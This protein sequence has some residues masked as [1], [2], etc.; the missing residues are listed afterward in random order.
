[1]HNFNIF[2]NI[3]PKENVTENIY[4]KIFGFISNQ[5]SEK[6]IIEDIKEEA[7]NNEENLEKMQEVFVI[8]NS[9]E[10]KNKEDNNISNNFNKKN[11]IIISDDDSRYFFTKRIAK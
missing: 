11:S 4:T 5:A 1:M 10:E 3:K 8:E 2:C 9:T 7:I 6:D